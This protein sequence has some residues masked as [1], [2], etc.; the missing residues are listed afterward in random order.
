MSIVYYIFYPNTDVKLQQFFE[1]AKQNDENFVYY[2][3]TL[4]A[5]CSEIIDMHEVTF[6]L[7]GL[8]FYSL[9]WRTSFQVSPIPHS[10]PYNSLRQVDLNDNNSSWIIFNV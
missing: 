2:W 4:F 9:E 5:L 6:C 3:F 10:N 1:S 8:I 7:F